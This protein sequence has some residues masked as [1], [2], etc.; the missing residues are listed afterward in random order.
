MSHLGTSTPHPNVCWRGSA[1][2]LTFSGVFGLIAGGSHTGEKPAELRTP[3]LGIDDE[4]T[5]ALKLTNPGRLRRLVTRIVAPSCH[6][7]DSMCAGA[8]RDIGGVHLRRLQGTDC[9]HQNK[10]ALIRC[11][12]RPG[13]LL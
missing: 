9:P 5:R 2:K 7:C 8:D 12:S 1:A 3:R 10:A 13:A 6:R 11:W 4:D